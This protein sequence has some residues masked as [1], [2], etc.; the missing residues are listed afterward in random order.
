MKLQ[1]L[2][3][4]T[5]LKPDIAR[6]SVANVRLDS[7]QVTPGDVFFALPGTQVDGAQFAKKADIQGAAAIIVGPSSDVDETITCPVFRVHDPA[8][9]VALAAAIIAGPQPECIVGVT[10]TAGK[11]SVVHFLRQIWQA[12]GIE[13]ASLGTIGVT[14]AQG[15]DYG[16]L[17]TP[18]AV[19]LHTK[20]AELAQDGVTAVALEA[21]SHGIVQRRL[22]G[23]SFSAVA[24]TN[25][26]RDHLDYHPTLE[27]YFM[28]KMRL[29]EALTP[30]DAP[31]VIDA[32][33]AMSDHAIQ[34]AEE[35]GLTVFTVGEKGE[36]LQLNSRTRTANGQQLTLGYQ[37]QTFDVALPLVGDFQAS[38]ALVALGLALATGSDVERSFAALDGLSGTP[39]RMELIGVTPDGASVFVDY[40]HKPDALRA[41]L[42]TVR[43]FTQGRLISVFG[44]GGDRDPGKRAMMGEISTEIADVT[45]V[46]DDNPRT[47]D[48]S[49]IRRAILKAAPGAIE[50]GDRREAIKA[51]I[52]DLQA[53]DSL[54]IAGKGHEEGQIIGD[55]V[56]PFSDQD[57]ARSALDRMRRT[58]KGLPNE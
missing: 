31:V 47:E 43:P 29:F 56:L 35:R 18:D 52:D 38:N 16:G 32:D 58:A 14:R 42:Q 13:A 37:H 41:V 4:E 7:R 17:T 49:T 46:T 10:G 45:I 9:A 6:L 57:E 44:C 2:L 40:A 15:T 24:F 19:S 11:S 8:R 21:S 48:P 33:G 30:E 20:L 3:P 53:G 28:A 27:A 39:G 12:N 22:D 54:V 50:I 5:P 25:L 23:V 1:D 51:A 36:T 26:G 34:V 55:Q